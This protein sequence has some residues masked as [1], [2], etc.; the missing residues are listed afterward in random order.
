MSGQEPVN[1][2]APENPKPG[3]K[4]LIAYRLTPLLDMRLAAAPAARDWMD[5][6]SEGF[7][8]R[9]LPMRIANQ[10]GWLLLNDRPVRAQ[11]LG[12]RASTDIVIE[13]SDA[14][15][16]SAISHFG[17]GILTFMLPYLFRTPSGIALLLRG[18][19]NSPKDA[20]SPLEGLV[21]TDWSVAGTTMNW[22][23]T[24]PHFW[25]EF[26]VGEPIGMIVPID[27]DLIESVQPSVREIAADPGRLRN[28]QA[29][30]DSCRAFTERLRSREPEA[31]KLGWQRYYFR[32]YAPSAEGESPVV[33]ENHRTK[34]K[35]SEFADCTSPHGHAAVRIEVGDEEST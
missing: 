1:S 33:A 15:P 17:E 18:P 25:V 34:L 13:Q 9:C 10:A 30:R 27:L 31:V 32:G 35:L 14:A 23:F 8:K 3:E 22:K 21:E 12:G 26:A 7:A 19:A 16:V 11:W 4:S 28:H 6:S 2:G 5:T 29:W 24:R 20:I